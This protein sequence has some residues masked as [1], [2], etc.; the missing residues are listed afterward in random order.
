MPVELLLTI[1]LLAPPLERY[2]AYAE[3][4][5]RLA[6]VRTACRTLEQEVGA[7]GEEIDRLI[8][9]GRK[10]AARALLQQTHTASESLT[11]CRRRE[12]ALDRDLRDLVPEVRREVE[13]ALDR[14]LTPGHPRQEAYEKI[15]PLLSILA[16]LGPPEG[17]PMENYDE[18]DFSA[19]D[20]PAA[21][22]MK[23]ML[24]QDILRRLSEN[25]AGDEARIRD[26]EA[27]R[28]LRRQLTRF[29]T[30][31]EV[32]GGTGLYEVRRSDAESRDRLRK[33]EE[34]LKGCGLALKVGETLQEHWQGRIRALEGPAPPSAPAAP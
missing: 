23:R 12:K 28:E 3:R 20:A 10:E 8:R 34:E 19:D 33:I 7:K 5:H 13:S 30:G 22:E 16:A 1:L 9:E 27:E 2:Q 26:L 6:E 15:R 32:E 17:C 24:M 29:M 4:E 18:I 31:L 11:D 14:S 25:R 21:L